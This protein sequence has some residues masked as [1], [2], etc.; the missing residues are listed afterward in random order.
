[1]YFTPV[2]VGLKA[3]GNLPAETL[4]NS[5]RSV[6]LKL[7]LSE[8]INGNPD[9]ERMSRTICTQATFPL[10]ST[11]IANTAIPLM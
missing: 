9:D 4:L 7:P 11:D 6:W 2:L 8:G 3:E 10:G 5:L 1:L